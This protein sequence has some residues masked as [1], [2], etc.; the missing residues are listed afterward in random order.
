MKKESTKTPDY[1][2][3]II[4]ER[5][6]LVGKIDRLSNF[7]DKDDFKHLPIIKKQLLY[8]QLSIMNSYEEILRLRMQIETKQISSLEDKETEMIPDAGN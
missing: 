8:S 6:D 7:I 4:G 2:E 1:V 5:N 3:R